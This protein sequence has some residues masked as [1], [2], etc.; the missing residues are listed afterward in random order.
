MTLFGQAGLPPFWIIWS[1]L[2]LQSGTA[3]LFTA[4]PAGDLMSNVRT[5]FGWLLFAV[6]LGS[7]ESVE[8]IVPTDL[9]AL[10][11]VNFCEYV[12]VVSASAMAA[13]AS[14]RTPTRAPTTSL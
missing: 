8:K 10:L 1:S 3:L 12:W 5:A 4:V 11:E 2:A 6:L 9:P 14:A 13:T 7:V